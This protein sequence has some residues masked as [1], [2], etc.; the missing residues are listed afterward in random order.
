MHCT[1]T[2][3]SIGPGTASRRCTDASPAS[4]P[5]DVPG[6]GCAFMSG[7]YWQYILC[8][9]WYVKCT[10]WG[11]RQ[12]LLCANC[13]C[14]TVYYCVTLCRFPQVNSQTAGPGGRTVYGADL[15]PLAWIA[16]SHSAES[17]NLLVLCTVAA[18]VKGW[19]LVQRSPTGCDDLIVCYVEI[20]KRGGLGPI[21]AKT[22]QRKELLQAKRDGVRQVCVCHASCTASPVT[23]LNTLRHYH[24]L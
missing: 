13:G 11:G 20:S 16:G 18:S 15:Q 19:S 2:H 23:Q 12:R 8:V 14:K 6:Y 4:T 22:L 17:M 24:S 3:C 1:S 5:D 9:S 10:P 21:W 7:V